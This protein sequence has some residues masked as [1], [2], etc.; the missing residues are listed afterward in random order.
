MINI[1][2]ISSNIS[3]KKYPTDKNQQI[4]S[5][6]TS[7]VNFSG[8]KNEKIGFTEGFGLLGKGILNQAKGIIDS[9]VK[10]PI[11]TLAVIGGTSL[12]LMLLPVIGI[13]TA[14]GGGIL[15]IGFAGLSVGKGISHAIQF[16]KNNEEG[17]YHLARKNLEQIG[18]DTV[19]LA[20]SVPFVP[21]S[22]IHVKNFAKY[23]KISYNK[24]LISEFL[25]DKNNWTALKNADKELSR[26]INYQKGVDIELK[27]LN[28]LSNAEKTD[29]KNKLF[30][31]NVPDDKIADIVLDKWAKAR[32]IKTK[33]T[34]KYQTLSKNNGGNAIA[35]DCSITLNDYKYNIPDKTF[36]NYQC[37]K[38]KLVNGKYEFTYKEINTG[39]II[40]ETIDKH[41]LDAYT[42]LYTQEADLSMQA[43][44]IL[45]TVHER[46][47]IH[48]Y[49]QINAHKGSSWCNPT[50]EAADL[51]RKMAQDIPPVQ[52]GSAKAIEIENFAN[53]INN[54]T[55]ISYIKNAREINA[56]NAE[57]KVLQDKNFKNLD[58][59][60]TYTNNMKP[61][62]LEKTLLLNSIRAQ[63][64]SV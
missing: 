58:N 19:D 61:E 6:K 50:P 2:I 16:A 25:T 31:F 53:A 12:A 1:P 41:I 38:R 40:Q 18:E 11:K 63:S 55:P 32:G 30:E 33:P 26:N 43:K 22:I 46:E 56:R 51:Y 47:H 34:I 36:N 48:Q 39:N 45:T 5:N 27:K 62:S 28:N 21:K 57:A 10:H 3:T 13:P 4:H 8:L 9:I 52:A 29:L 35:K 54:G 49:A 14:V 20:L 42:G 60:F 37:L 24:Q 23:G 44:R 7:L 17:T 59:V 64:A 15:A